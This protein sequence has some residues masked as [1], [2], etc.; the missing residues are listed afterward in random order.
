ML[1]VMGSFIRLLHI[2]INDL[3]CVCLL[4]LRLPA[5]PV[6]P[7]S[8]LPSFVVVFCYTHPYPRATGNLL[9]PTMVFQSTYVYAYVILPWLVIDIYLILVMLL[10]W[11][12][13]WFFSGCNTQKSKCRIFSLKTNSVELWQMGINLSA[14]TSDT[15]QNK[16][17]KL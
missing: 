13:I 17:G 7:R 1:S 12:W 11:I 3:P 15:E 10:L 2:C 14:I 9:C 6:F 16:V 8:L 5:L 4:G